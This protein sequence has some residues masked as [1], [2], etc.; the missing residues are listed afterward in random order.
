MTLHV[1]HSHHGGD[2]PHQHDSCLA[3]LS[4]IQDF[5]HQEVDE[6]TADLIREHLQA[7]ESCLDTYD[8]ET[9]I[10]ALIIF[11]GVRSISAVTQIL[12]PVMAILYIGLGLIVVAMNI[13]E[14][15]HVFAQIIEGA[16]GIREFVTGGV[17][18]VIMQGVK[19]GIM[20]IADII[21]V[22][23]ADGAL[24]DTA[25]RTVADYAGALRLM[26]KRPYDPEGFP[27][28]LP[29]SA[30]TGLGLDT[31]WARMTALADW[32]RDYGHFAARRAEQARH[33]FLADVRAGLLARLEQ[34]KGDG[35]FLATQNVDGLH[36]RAGSK[37]LVELHGNL[38][39]ARDEKT[40]EI[41]LLATPDELVTPPTSP[42]GNRMRPNVVW[43]GEFLPEDA[44]EAAQDAFAAADVA[45][46]I[47]TS[48]V[49]YPAAGLALETLRRGGTVIE[50]NPDETELTPYMSFSLR[51]K[52]SLGLAQL[53]GG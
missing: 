16:F 23:K 52:A 19:R 41:F 25:L 12:V 43:F 6:T 34:E 53:L 33:W 48:G 20:E 36:A 44:L 40:G 9:A 1:S 8:V 32:R 13:G 50:V 3:A 17:I 47:G 2:E 4:R 11:G 30:Q 51:E 28:A 7:C 22:N 15:P 31:A 35:F 26:R 45:L 21:L 49:V 38:L 18:G 46:V 42:N 39:S 24:H 27:Q 29:V 37:R 14:V 10:T 5:L